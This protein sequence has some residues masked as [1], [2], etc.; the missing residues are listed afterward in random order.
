MKDVQISSQTAQMA[1]D[2]C[3]D[4]GCGVTGLHSDQNS[5]LTLELHFERVAS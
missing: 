2:D 4:L 1:D 5:I 3:F